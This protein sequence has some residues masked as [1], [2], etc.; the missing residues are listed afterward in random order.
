[1]GDDIFFLRKNL[2]EA[3]SGRSHGQDSRPTHVD[4]VVEVV[5]RNV[6][7]DP[8]DRTSELLRVNVVETW[9]S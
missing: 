1:M 5:V 9:V 3:D 4:I 2:W 7:R 8:S 6:N